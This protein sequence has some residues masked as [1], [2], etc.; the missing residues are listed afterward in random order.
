M[1][2]YLVVRERLEAAVGAAALKDHLVFTT[3]PVDE[4]TLRA[5]GE[6][7]GVPMF[8]LPDGVGGRFSVLSAVGL[9]PAALMGMDVVALL[10][11]ARGH[12]R[13]VSRRPR[14]GTTRPAP[15][16]GSSTWKTR[17]S[18]GA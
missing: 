11:G 10:A 7:M 13:D 17:S 14:P 8:D 2:G 12:G 5:L 18:A 15:S 9:V 6:T 4:G 1:A 3:D 16:P